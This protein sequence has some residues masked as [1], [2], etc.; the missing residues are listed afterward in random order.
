[1]DPVAQPEQVG[2][3]LVSYRNKITKHDQESEG[4]WPQTFQG[5][6]PRALILPSLLHFL[7][8]YAVPF[9]LYSQL[10][11]SLN[12]IHTKSDCWVALVPPGRQPQAVRC[13][14]PEGPQAIV[15]FSLNPGLSATFWAVKRKVSWPTEEV[16]LLM[17]STSNTS[18]KAYPSSKHSDCKE[19]N[20]L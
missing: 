2:T 15:T 12:W 11:V 6:G 1:M 5:S 16:P 19:A 10:P 14:R 3:P 7:C 13:E 8:L 18:L 20:T 9:T 17:T 4:L